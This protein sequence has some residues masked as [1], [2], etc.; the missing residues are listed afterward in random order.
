MSKVS[1]SQPTGI[2]LESGEFPNLNR[3]V[4]KVSNHSPEI[5]SEGE[6]RE[7]IGLQEGIGSSW[8]PRIP[9]PEVEAS[10]P[11]SA[12]RFLALNESG[13]QRIG[14]DHPRA[15]LTNAQVEAIRDKYEAGIA[16]TGPRIGYRL[17]ARQFGVSKRT[18]RDIVS[19]SS[20]N[21]WA[22]RWKRVR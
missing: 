9:P 3:A 16:G 17:L 4:S 1:N 2:Q 11:P 15:R 10:R 5:I 13:T 18:I 14:E 8:I 22:A 21:Q 7:K 6:K 19:Y 12:K 20:R